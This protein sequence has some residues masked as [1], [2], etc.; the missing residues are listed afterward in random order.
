MFLIVILMIVLHNQILYRIVMD[1]ELYHAVL[2]GD[3]KFF[4]NLQVSDSY[5]LLE[6]TSGHK[7]SIIHVA[8]K[9]GEMQIAEKLIALC[10]SLLHQTNAKGD[11]PLHI[12]A[13]LGR[14]QMTQLLINCA[15]LVEVEGEKKL[16]RMQNLDKDTALHEAARNGHFEIVSLLIYE[17]PELAQI[18]NNAGESS[19][20]LALDRKFYK[21]A[22]LIL[23][24]APT[25]SYGGR[26]SMN[27]LHMAI[28]RADKSKS[29]NVV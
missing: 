13:R 6:V 14:F 22:R 12:A 8:A 3:K 5:D 24:V 28:I 26:N 20:F 10:P 21:I 1:R 9:C 16:V 18:V 25:C 4:E 2:H 29:L 23:E 11:S 15:K 27:V 19:L 17:D 7:N